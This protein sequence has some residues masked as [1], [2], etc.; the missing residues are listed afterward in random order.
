MNHPNHAGLLSESENMPQHVFDAEWY[1]AHYGDAGTAITDPYQHYLSY[2]RAEGRSPTREIWELAEFARV[3]FDAE[4]YAEQ[5][6]DVIEAGYRPLDHYLRYGR[7]E[8][9]SSSQAAADQAVLAELG[10]ESFDAR[11]YGLNN[12]DVIEAGQDPLRHYLTYGRREGRPARSP[13][14]G[15]LGATAPDRAPLCWYYI[16][17]TIA[18][19]ASHGHLTGVCRVT[20][21]ILF[22]GLLDDEASFIPCVKGSSPTGLMRLRDWSAMDTLAR[23]AGRSIDEA[24]AAERSAASLQPTV[25]G[26]ERGDHVVFTGVV[27]TAADAVLFQHLVDS[28]VTFSVLINDIIPVTQP[29][30]VDQNHARSFAAWLSVAVRTASVIY[31]STRAVARDIAGWVVDTG[32]PSTASIVPIAF[33]SR[34]VPSSADAVR[35]I[36]DGLDM[37]PF[38]LCV[39]TID[40]RKNQ[41]LLC[42]V[43]RDLVANAS[44]RS[45][46]RLVLVGRDDIGL[47]SEETLSP[48]IN[49][50]TILVLSD[51]SDADVAALYRACLFTVFPSTSEGYGLPVSESLDHG[52]LCVS[53]DL[54]VVRSHAD[55]FVW[56]FDAAS[57]DEAFAQIDRAISRPDQRAAAETHIRRERRSIPWSETVASM[58]ATVDYVM[59]GRDAVQTYSNPHF[60]RL[61]ARMSA[62]GGARD[63]AGVVDEGPAVSILIANR[64][65][66][67]ATLECVRQIRAHTHG[68]SYEI[69]VI[70]NGSSEGDLHHLRMLVPLATLIELGCDRFSGEAFNIA[71]ERARGHHLCIVDTSADL[72]VGWLMG[73]MQDLWDDR[74]AAAVALYSSTLVD[75]KRTMPVSGQVGIGPAE[76][77]FADVLVVERRVFLAV[78]GFDLAYE[79]GPYQDVDLCLKIEG[80]GRTVFRSGVSVGSRPD[81]LSGVSTAEDRL[82][83]SLNRE[84]LQARWGTILRDRDKTAPHTVRPASAISE[85]HQPWA[86]PGAPRAVLYTP[87]PLTPGGGERYLLSLAAMLSQTHAVTLALPH[88]YSRLRIL[89]LGAEFGLDLNS[90]AV[91]RLDDQL[92][93]SRPDIL[94][95]MSNQIVPP[96]APFGQRNFFIC[97]FPFPMQ[98]SVTHADKERIAG[99]EAI[100]AYSRYAAIHIEAK[101]HA[102]QAADVPV[103]VIPPPVESFGPG[104]KRQGTIMTVGRFFVGGHTKRHDALIEAFK[105]L[106]ARSTLP[107]ELHVVGSTTPLAMHMNYLDDLIKSASGYP[108]YFHINVSAESLRN[109]Y[110]STAV[111]WHAAGLGADLTAEPWAAEHFGISIVEAMMAGAVPFVLAS[112]GPREIIHHG[113]DGFHYDTLE[114]LIDQT[115]TFHQCDAAQQD[116]LSVEAQRQSQNFSLEVF[117]DTVRRVILGTVP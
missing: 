68:I 51:L 69:I 113:V 6:S 8:G 46:P 91:E 5:N 61:D 78:G 3:A 11:W 103:R 85:P 71:A 41:L 26:P 24:I 84:K 63:S 15:D 104:V 82:V 70:D 110:A 57:R 94:V 48:L 50:G 53:S 116:A 40:K 100:V 106:Q 67:A 60:E 47:S 55:D 92:I 108:I 35:R 81:V 43:W 21:E 72:A 115:A 88:L 14:Q 107:V 12:P 27:W 39:G 99:Y 74:K 52:K 75:L 86:K 66:A 33:G 54:P 58:R 59:A 65:A 98:A 112:G 34:L 22:A 17:D 80:R 96:V 42:R 90:V 83:R 18:W 29:E 44:D 4:W 105:A 32:L 49:D 19:A 89:A 37:T 1:I 23:L 25:A 30:L 95:G 20:S 77:A 31:V 76:A 114:T 16:G 109:L 111:Y 93:A 38:V 13:M 10:R 28:G 87:Y 101:L 97:Q 62:L 36:A 79:P 73:A 64:N 102:I 2:G 45:V 56:Y 9:R 117:T 7:S